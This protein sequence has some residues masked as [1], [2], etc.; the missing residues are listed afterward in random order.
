M[1]R[2]GAL[3]QHEPLTKSLRSNQSLPLLDWS[4]ARRWPTVSHHVSDWRA[5]LQSFLWKSS[6]QLLSDFQQSCSADFF[7]AKLH[8]WHKT[9]RAWKSRD[10]VAPALLFLQ[11]FLNCLD[12]HIF[13]YRQTVRFVSSIW[14]HTR[15]R[16]QTKQNFTLCVFTV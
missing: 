13:K 4:P 7:A 12:L 11:Y 6:K 16:I 2:T 14:Q 1:K 3:S 8:R 9:L 10:N 5:L 15:L